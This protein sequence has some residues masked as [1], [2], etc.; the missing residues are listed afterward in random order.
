M[1]EETQYEVTAVVTPA[2]PAKYTAE[3]I[4][5]FDSAFLKS[6]QIIARTT[7]YSPYDVTPDAMTPEELAEQSAKLATALLT[8]R[9]KLLA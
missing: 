6:A 7:C 3:E 4:A 5:F 2:Q 9:R 8:E 1:T